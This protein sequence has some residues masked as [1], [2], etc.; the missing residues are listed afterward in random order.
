MQKILNAAFAALLLSANIASAALWTH[1]SE[2]GFEAHLL[3]TPQGTLRLTCDTDAERAGQFMQIE[4]HGAATPGDYK[5]QIGQ[6][7][8]SLPVARE[9]IVATWTLPGVNLAGFAQAFASAGDITVT[10]PDG[11]ETVFKLGNDRPAWC[12]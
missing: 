1:V 11:S 9:I 8:I 7:S 3:K 12:L 5:I 6:K 4:L 10:G 2:R